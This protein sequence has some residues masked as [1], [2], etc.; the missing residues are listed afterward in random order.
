MTNVLFAASLGGGIWK[1]S[2]GGASWQSSGGDFLPSLNVQ[3]LAVDPNNANT[4]Y[5]GTGGGQGVFKST[6]GGGN[7]AQLPGSMASAPVPGANQFWS[8]SELA[9]FKSG[10]IVAAVGDGL[11]R[12]GDGGATWQIILGENAIY[13]IDTHPT[14][15]NQAVATGGDHWQTTD[16]GLNW[17]NIDD[18][19][20]QPGEIAYAKS[21]PQIIYAAD[22]ESIIP[23]SD[24]SDPPQTFGNVA[25]SVDGGVTFAVVSPSNLD[26]V[27]DLGSQSSR[28]VLMVDPTDANHV[29]V[30]SNVLWRSLDGGSTWEQIGG[31]APGLCFHDAQPDAQFTVN[32]VVYLSS[33]LGVYRVNDPFGA[34]PSAPFALGGLRIAH[35]AGASS[36]VGTS[37]VF[38]SSLILGDRLFQGAP[39]ATVDAGASN[40]GAVAAG[41]SLDGNGRASFYAASLPGQIRRTTFNTNGSVF[42]QQLFDIPAEDAPTPENPFIPLPSFVRDPN[43]DGRF[44][45]GGKS[46]WRSENLAPPSTGPA[47]WTKSFQSTVPEGTARITAI[48]IEEGNSDNLWI[49]LDDGS[50][51]HSTNGSSVSPTWIPIAAPP[52]KGICCSAEPIRG[53]A[54]DRFTHAVYLGL[55]SPFTDVDGL[56][57]STNNGA[58]WIDIDQPLSNTIYS[59]FVNPLVADRVYVGTPGGFFASDDAG[60]TW[61]SAN[62][63]P[64]NTPVTSMSLLGNSLTIG[65]WGRGVFRTTADN[66]KVTVTSPKNNGSFITGNAVVLEAAA[67]DVGG[68]IASVSFQVNGGSVGSPSSTAPYSTIWTPSTTGVFKITAVATNNLGA[69]TVSSAV[70]VRIVSG[71]SAKR[72][73]AADSFVK[74]GDPAADKGTVN[75]LEIKTAPAAQAGNNRDTYLKF[76][77]SSITGVANQIRFRL[78]GGMNQ[79]APATLGVYG[80][81]NTSWIETGTGHICWN[82]RPA[83]GS[84]LDTRDVSSAT[85][86]TQVFDIT[87]YVRAARM[88]GQSTISLGVHMPIEAAQYFKANSREASSGK[89]ELELLTSTPGALLVVG[90]TTLNTGDA[91]IKSR[92]QAIGFTV[93]VKSATSAVTTDATGKLLVFIS[94][95]VKSTD[96][97]TKFRDVAAPVVNC[98]PSIQDD[99]RF[100]AAGF[101]TIDPA[102]TTL[103]I[104]PGTPLSAG[105]SGPQTVATVASKFGYAEPNK[106]G[107]ILVNGTFDVSSLYAYEKGSQMVGMAAPARRVELFLADATAASLTAAG[108]SLFDA[109]VYWASGL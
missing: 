44:Y 49:G 21:N 82:N 45:L 50:V 53:I 34:S 94:S 93:T 29:L 59:V 48:G 63:G 83:L 55:E 27:S 31:L 56:F 66:T 58:T 73:A 109:A 47:V 104:N 103:S 19:V 40:G 24:P 51:Y 32:H 5:A 14:D 108:W 37:Q 2:D 46:L 1:S 62:L 84:L 6:D 79:A 69:R 17:F 74:D 54:I 72:T 22:D 76:S 86:A 107:V 89:P 10:V 105:F 36:H 23:P 77:I 20:S 25:R 97:N 7:W 68:S 75:P 106:A 60:A 33:D 80:V 92:L 101:G 11:A 35:V 57:K 26:L 78:T 38:S 70:S 12:S 30:G 64:A 85:V 13:D 98:E 87:S 91:A 39:D 8:F 41:Q 102:A 18:K 81:S 90:N 4:I 96:V 71:T 52:W 65:T 99:M 16:G 43:T 95:T 100:T 42:A 61:S 9:V 3:S 67:S 88:A 28:F 15:P